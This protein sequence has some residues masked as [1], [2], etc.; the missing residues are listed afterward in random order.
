MRHDNGSMDSPGV[1]PLRSLDGLEVADGYAD[2]RGWS[3]SREDGALLGT[4]RELLVDPDGMRV[5]YLDVALAHGGEGSHARMPVDAVRIDTVARTVVA[6]QG[7]ASPEAGPTITAERTAAGRAGVGRG[8]KGSGEEEE[9]RIPVV[10][11]EFVVTKRPVVK[12]E[13]VV[14]RHAVQEDQTIEADL[15]RERVDFDDT[16]SRGSG[17]SDRSSDVGMRDR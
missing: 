2:V 4:V 6:P 14:T 11:E 9:V 3:V 5:T 10:E 16:R 17:Q 13:I 1:Q 15:K 7:L 8:T 12:E